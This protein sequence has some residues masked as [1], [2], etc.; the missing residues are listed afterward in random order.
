MRYMRGGSLLSALQ[1]G[2]WR[3]E[4]AAAM[5]EQVAGALAAAHRMGVVHRDIKPGNILL[6]EAGNAYLADFGIATA[7]SSGPQVTPDG[8][9]ASTLDYI[10]PEQILGEPVTPQTDVYS[11][12]AV[13]YETLTGEKPFADVPVARL[14]Y[15]QLHDP[16]PLVTASRPDIPA[17]VDEVLQK[18]TAKQPAARYATALE[19]A[20]AFR[21]AAGGL[22]LATEP[23]R[24]EGWPAA[25][26][27][28]N[29]YKGLHAF[30]EADAEHFFGREALVQQ[31]VARLA[32]PANGQDNRFLAVVGP[33]GSGKSSVVKA[34]LIPALRDG[35]LPGSAN[36]FVAE[37]VP[38]KNPLEEL[39][40]ALWRVAVDPPP[41]LVAPMQRDSRGILRTIRR[42]LP[43]GSTDGHPQ[44][45]LVI[46]QFEELFT[47]VEDQAERDFFLDSLLA[48]LAAPRSPLRLVVTLRAD[49]YD[50]PL[51]YQEWGQLFK[52]N[53]EIVLPL[54]STELTW[55][56]RE[57][58][59]M[60]GV[61][62]E[63]GL[64][65]AIVTAVVDQPGALPLLQYA[66][67]E[68]FERRE[69]RLI[70]R[71][72]YERLGGVQGAL[73]QRAE[74]VYAGLRA[75]GQELARQ[76]FLRLVTLGEGSEDT[77]RR[78]LRAELEALTGAEPAWDG[79]AQVVKDVLDS[80]GAGRFLTFDHDPATRA[81]TVEVAHE[82]LLR[83]W[84]RLRGWLAANRD[85][86]RQ[87]RLL[88]QA[89]AE[90]QSAGR[91]PG[92]LLR[93][94]RLDQFGGWAETPAL[95]LTEDERAFLEASL[96]ARQAR[97]A[98]EEDRR[99]R[100]LQAARDLAE[101][102]QKRAEEQ[103]SAA[104]RLRR[105]AFFLAGALVVA[106]I[107]A[108]VATASSRQSLANA[109]LAAANA[110]EAQT[111]A[112][113]AA[114]SAAAAEASAGLAQTRESEEAL[115]RV[116][117]E[118]ARAT[119]VAAE[120]VA[121]RERETAEQQSAYADEQARLATSRE[122][123]LVAQNTLALDPELSILLSLHALQTAYTRGAED[124]LHQAL[125]KSRL[126]QAIP[127]VER[128]SFN[129]DGTQVATLDETELQVWELA[130]ERATLTVTLPAETFTIAYSPDG[131]TLAT[132][133]EDGRV[134]LWD[135]AT[136]APKRSFDD[137]PGSVYSVVFSLD[138]SRLASADAE[139]VVLLRDLESGDTLFTF[140]GAFF[141][142]SRV[143][144][145]PDGTL[146]AVPELAANLQ[147]S[148]T[149]LNLWDVETGRLRMTA[150]TS[151]LDFS[152]SPDGAFLAR[153]S[154]TDGN[155]YSF[156]VWDLPA[157]LATGIVQP[158][159]TLVGHTAL[160]SG[161]AFSPDGSLIATSSQ[162]GTVKLWNPNTGELLFTLAGHSG[163]VG[164]PEFSPDGRRLL[165]VAGD[166]ARLW[167]VSLPGH[168]EVMALAGPDAMGNLAM[169]LSPDG[170]TLALGGVSGVIHLHDAASGERLAVL[171]G[172]SQGVFQLAFSPD[173]S[174]LASAGTDA[175]VIVWD[176][177]R[178]LAAGQGQEL[179]ALRGHDESAITG[180]LWTGVLGVDY[181]PDGAR[182]ATGGTD[183]TV[184]LWDATSGEQLESVELH[185]SGVWSV[186]FSA[187]GRYLVASS[188]LQDAV[189][190]VWELEGDGLVERY[191]LTGFP[192]RV[193]SVTFSPDSTYLLTT[194][195]AAHMALWD[196]ATGERLRD[197]SG[198]VST[199]PR[200]VFSPDGST[201]ASAGLDGTIRIWDVASGATLQ[202][203]TTERPNWDIAFSPDGAY[204]YASD[205]VGGL[206]VY[207]L[208]LDT[209]LR[210]ARQRLT[211]WFT[212]AECLQYLHQE[213]CPEP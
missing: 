34:G 103:A 107:L 41:D 46:D 51:Q 165:T 14:L 54:N 116:A 99:Q 176:V 45:L 101:A 137:H 156:V 118:Q 120:A 178:S 123:A 18:A 126:R 117:A 47:L 33:S 154:N 171:G 69:G 148:E 83:E 206:N 157:S 26:E 184:R 57:P 30:Q 155:D 138:G 29:P 144:F 189:V 158:V 55:A 66:L 212:P 39:E 173:G 17:A 104:Q 129:P 81:P 186:R 180:G 5:L 16:I 98:A 193:G 195:A 143:A 208:E 87:Q 7:L 72:A 31:L 199:V 202:T 201:V 90:W 8:A 133:D 194:G 135:A 213:T 198:H 164:Y 124:S 28:V 170:A 49:F 71:A 58:A 94:A 112:N 147:T 204:L 1:S 121:N 12:G 60:M 182:L 146:L 43:A 61:R 108:M 9:V 130:T 40:L 37:M 152:F 27:V 20:A 142:R 119:A 84:P 140:P 91:D 76:L 67:T 85:E 62:L 21:D 168:E 70:S 56:V 4:R 169:A 92:F 175:V 80:F 23:G 203:F 13:L 10:S 115:Q 200:A 53:S 161:S 15:S 196:T 109:A 25:L 96:A 19:M 82:A 64:E 160:P 185:P 125:Q 149:A 22:E 163:S 50:R 139:G 136:G 134:I 73:G 177:P 114:T 179:L 65:A 79:S 100:E 38:G 166:G 192:S 181:S 113:S 88:A 102:Q 106:A 205:R 190:R 145:S 95:A 44:L 207:A 97:L 174:R 86:V 11:L 197:F 78:V 151:V 52:D 63:D 59:R 68:L 122:L 24:A 74:A 188:E 209:L 36:W 167:D 210:L 48:A 191:T 128:A 42:I 211:R 111:N 172:H 131:Q 183:G 162:D 6:D 105:R 93:G 2:P 3:V 187:N 132:G 75:S 35:A 89:A 153:G 110:A 127:G 77:R 159:T 32:R 141:W 150:G